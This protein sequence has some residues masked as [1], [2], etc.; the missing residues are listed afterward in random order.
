[1][2]VRPDWLSH[3]YQKAVGSEAPDALKYRVGVGFGR[4]FL[5]NLGS[6]LLPQAALA[7]C[8][9]ALLVPGRTLLGRGLVAVERSDERD[10]VIRAHKPIP[11]HQLYDVGIPLPELDRI[12]R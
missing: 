7:H 9:L 8:I 2:T 3:G 6:L 11:G 12:Y 10:N 1:M 4:T 5:S